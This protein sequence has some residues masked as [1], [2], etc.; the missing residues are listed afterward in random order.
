M[1]THRSQRKSI[2]PVV[3]FVAAV[4]LLASSVYVV[5]QTEQALVTQFGKPVRVII[6]P[7]EGAKREGIL[8]K[9][10]GQYAEEGISVAEGAGL[11]FKLPFIQDVKKFERRLLRWNGLPEQIPTKD[12]KY[13]WVDSTARWYIQDPLLFFRSVGTEEQAHARLDDTINA[14]TRNSITK[15]D[16][17]EIVR[18][19]NRDMQVAEEELQETTE[20]GRVEEG[21][22]KIV[23]EITQ[24][25]RKE[26]E[27]IRRG[28][29]GEGRAENDRGEASD[30]EETHLRGRGP[31]RE[32]HGGQGEGC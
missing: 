10:K 16:L 13:I 1:L 29:Q 30:S 19:S 27:Y 9:L 15:R 8:A 18:T 12:K 6:N 22:P 3:V 17:I 31:V 24:A 28:C 5:D 20:V 11:R 23:A 2:L 4:L 25:S 32:D 7:I 14:S 26:C 21:R